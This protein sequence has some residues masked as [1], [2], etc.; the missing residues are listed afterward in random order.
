MKLYAKGIC[1][2]HKNIGEKCLITGRR[3]YVDKRSLI[4]MNDSLEDI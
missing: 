2:V 1:P 4:A 3:N